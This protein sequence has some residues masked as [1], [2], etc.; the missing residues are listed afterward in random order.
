MKHWEG[1][2]TRSLPPRFGLVPEPGTALLIA[3]GLAGLS[4]QRKS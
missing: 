3:L 4:M 2:G 1:G